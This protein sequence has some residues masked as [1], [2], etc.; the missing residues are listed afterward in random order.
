MSSYQQRQSDEESTFFTVLNDP[1]MW[2]IMKP[3][4]FKKSRNWYS[5]TNADIAIANNY[6]ELIEDRYKFMKLSQRTIYWAAKK[7]HKKIIKW[8]LY[9]RRITNFQIWS[10]P[11]FLS[12][13]MKKAIKYNNMP[14]VKMWHM[15]VVYKFELVFDEALAQKNMEMIDF[16]IKNNTNKHCTENTI[17]LAIEHGLY[18]VLEKIFA[19]F[20]SI[21]SDDKAFHCA[22][23]NNNLNVLIF[24]HEHI[25]ELNLKRRKM[26]I[27]SQRNIQHQ[28]GRIHAHPHYEIDIPRQQAVVS[29]KKIT[30]TDEQ[31]KFI[32]KHTIYLAASN[33]Y[34]DII[35]WLHENKFIAGINM[36]D[37]ILWSAAKGNNL[38]VIE[39][40]HTI[41]PGTSTICFI[42][43]CNHIEIVKWFYKHNYRNVSDNFITIIIDNFNND[44]D[45]N[46][47]KKKGYLNERIN[48]E[49]I[50]KQNKLDIFLWTIQNIDNIN[51]EKMVH[52]AIFF[53]A[54]NILH[55]LA[56]NCDN[57]IDC[58]KSY[59]GDGISTM[60]CG[61]R[62][63]IPRSNK[64]SYE[65]Y[66]EIMSSENMKS[67]SLGH[68]GGWSNSNTER[69]SDYEVV[70]DAEPDSS[71]IVL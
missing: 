16:L 69:W 9:N 65:L 43:A 32:K 48:I 14:I 26:A 47:L 70:S 1:Y 27:D 57:F 53:S 23:E 38:N 11:I 64:H 40:I 20:Q 12:S 4:M 61:G 21:T 58:V 36:I 29:D 13:V 60:Y 54:N 62:E 51:M 59:S 10:D 52:H 25:E 37:D 46:W 7:G 42:E 8:V 5:Y 22:I 19:E 17:R 6:H 41:Q 31:N 44:H 55:Y 71:T 63:P 35:Q 33:G 30:Y 67:D 28:Q 50:I 49:Y 18:D 2:S 66:P 56:I 68:D 3:Y 24:L 45:L 39:W 15:C 34:L